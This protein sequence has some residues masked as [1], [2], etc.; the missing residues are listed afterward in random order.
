MRATLLPQTPLP[1]RRTPE[2]RESLRARSCSAVLSRH[3]LELL[4]RVLTH[5]RKAEAEHPPARAGVNLA[6]GI[7]GWLS[8]PH[9][10]SRAALHSY[11]MP[12]MLT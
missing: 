9:V 2:A 8:L 7:Q 12:T 4:D 6:A 11:K 5:V 10:E 1:E 3:T